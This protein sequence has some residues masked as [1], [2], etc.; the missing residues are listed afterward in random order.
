MGVVRA[1]EFFVPTLLLMLGNQVMYQKFFS[2]RSER[3]ARISVVGWT[4]GTLVLETL[5]VAIA[6]FRP[7]FIKTL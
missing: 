7:R 1:L 4:L 3:D 2:A 6:V 5:I